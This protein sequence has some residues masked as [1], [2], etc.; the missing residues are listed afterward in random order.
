M[1]YTIVRQAV[2]RSSTDKAVDIGRK[3]DNLPIMTNLLMVFQG[4]KQAGN[5]WKIYSSKDYDGAYFRGAILDSF[6]GSSIR[7]AKAFVFDL[8]HLSHYHVLDR[9]IQVHSS[10]L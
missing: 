2:W 4:L 3:R 1:V 9:P 5:S 7:S 6:L 8:P 10:S